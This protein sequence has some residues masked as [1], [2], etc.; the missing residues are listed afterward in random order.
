MSKQ[1][2]SA[3]PKQVILSQSSNWSNTTIAG[4]VTYADVG[5]YGIAIALGFFL[6]STPLF[7]WNWPA[8]IAYIAG[9]SIL[10]GKTPTKRSVV[11]NIYPILF[12]KQ[13]RM[14]V[15]DLSTTTTIGHGIREVVIDDVLGMP[16]FKMNDGQYC[17]VFNIT[18]GINRWS[19]DVD[20]VHQA[21]YMKQVFNNLE[22]GEQFLIVTKNDRDTDML[23]LES[24]LAEESKFDPVANPDLARMAERRLRLLHNVATMENG[25]SVQQY[26]ILKIKKRSVKKM[27]D[28]LRS[29]CR[30]IRPAT[31]PADILLSAMGFE[32]GSE[33]R[34]EDD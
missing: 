33:I 5:T 13:V 25:R 32:G 10:I 12:K 28:R 8:I 29:A 23:R 14:V 3:P 2:R 27:Y 1:Q 24:E 16:A 26:G 18:S 20:Y 17:Y 21:A 11:K 6:L 7:K 30:I 4:P 19:T 9:V 22:A 31:N 15:S 34:E